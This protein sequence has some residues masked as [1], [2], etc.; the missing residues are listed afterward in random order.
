MR[1]QISFIILVYIG[2]LFL[3][4][5]R[6]NS[7]ITQTTLLSDLTLNKYSIEKTALDEVDLFYPEFTTNLIPKSTLIARYYLHYKDFDKAINYGIRGVESNPYLAYTNYL[8]ARIYIEK[9]NLP[10]AFEYM[11]EAYRLSPKIESIKAP[12]DILNQLIKD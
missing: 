10:K 3:N 11:K 12:Y 2:V 9:N 8:M 1:V 4:L 6:F 7:Y 5:M